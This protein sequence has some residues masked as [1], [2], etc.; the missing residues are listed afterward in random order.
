MRRLFKQKNDSSGF[1]LI[2]VLVALTILAIAFGAIVKVFSSILVSTR[3]TEEYTHAVLFAES[4]IDLLGNSSYDIAESLAND[5]QGK[6]Q[7]TTY[8]EPYLQEQDFIVQTQWKPHLVTVEVK[9]GDA[10]GEKS[11]S[12]S[13]TTLRLLKN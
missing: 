13:L 7:V 3:K 4:Q 9:W 1:S 8:V 6:Y 2:E 5:P 12:L 10:Q 11:K